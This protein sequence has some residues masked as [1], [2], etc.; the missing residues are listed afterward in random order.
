MRRYKKLLMPLLLTLVLAALFAIPA[1]AADNSGIG[2]MLGD[3]TLA[4]SD[5][6]PTIKDGRVFVPA[7][8]V[9]E[10]MGAEVNYH[11]ENGTVTAARGGTTVTLTLGQKNLQVTTAE[12]T[13]TVETDAVPFVEND[14]TLVPV[15]FAAEGFGCRVGWNADERNVLIFDTEDMLGDAHYTLL[16][17][18]LAYGQDLMRSGYA[19]RGSFEMKMEYTEDGTAVPILINGTMDGLCDSSALNLDVAYSINMDDFLAAMDPEEAPDDTTLLILQMMKDIRMEYIFNYEDGMLYLRSPLLSLAMGVTDSDAWISIDLAAS[20]GSYEEMVGLM[21]SGTTADYLAAV[22]DD[23]TPYSGSEMKATVE[24]LRSFNAMFSDEAFTRDGDVYTN[25]QSFEADGTAIQTK[26]VFTM[27]GE[28]FGALDMDFSMSDAETSMQ[29]T[30][31]V[32]HDG[33]AEMTMN[34][35]DVDSNMTYHYTMQYTETDKVP[36]TEPE[37]GSTIIPMG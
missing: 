9:W 6:E 11:A 28:E 30:G 26:I 2:V 34:M 14:R 16:D 18:Y 32:N 21:Q 27:D 7:R 13:R 19:M 23:Y 1:F 35:Q 37:E 22:L 12:G 36:V 25:T 15:R 8:A 20:E 3:Q 4:F 33:S 5:V 10:A 24:G 31:T 17:S 29:L